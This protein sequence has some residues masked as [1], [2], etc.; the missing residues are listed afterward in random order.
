MEEVADVL[1][2]DLI[3]IGQ[4]LGFDTDVVVRVVELIKSLNCSR[5]LVQQ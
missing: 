2:N 4:R 1:V 5:G 3:A